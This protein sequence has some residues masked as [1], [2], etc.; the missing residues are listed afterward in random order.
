[1]SATLAFA[2]QWAPY[3][4]EAGATLGVDPNVILG[5]W[6]LE[7]G[8]GTNSATTQNNNPGAI[9]SGSSPASYASQQAFEQYYV[10]TI[11]ND[12]P[13]A[14][15]SGSNAVA[16]SNALA[17]GVNGSYFG[18][19]TNAATYAAGI[20]GAEGN[21]TGNVSS[22]STSS[23]TV[24]GPQAVSST[25]SNCGLLT[26][27]VFTWSCWSGII[28]DGMLVVLGAGMMF[29]AFLSTRSS[30]VTINAA[31]DVALAATAG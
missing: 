15:G 11:A 26:G 4:Q 24:S 6:A 1:M 22:S 7:S 25:T 16:F 27:G 2:N 20:L 13:N 28:A 14:V 5:Q 21:L 31:K 18:S 17:S 19:G 29:A 12:F 10:N 30:G 3:A 8:Y 9:M 23:P